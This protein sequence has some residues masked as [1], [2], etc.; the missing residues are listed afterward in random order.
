MKQK[1][2][3]LWILILIFIGG[4]A[5]AKGWVSVEIPLIYQFSEEGN[6]PFTFNSSLTGKPSGYIIYGSIYEKPF[7][8]FEKYQ[9]SVDTDNSDEPTAIIDV[10][11]IDIGL[12]FEQKNSHFLIGYGQG[13]IKM[14]CQLSACSDYKFEEGIAYQYFIQLGVVLIDKLN[15]SLSTHR[16]TGKNDFKI[17]S[18]SDDI[19]LD[20]IMY[21]FGLKFS[22]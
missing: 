13:S 21:A 1:L 2:F 14:E 8:G 9:I 20:G 5:I 4:E 11:F 3:I 18:V 12:N 17:G 6:S 16:V 7:L 22:W 15:F 19:E 10:Q